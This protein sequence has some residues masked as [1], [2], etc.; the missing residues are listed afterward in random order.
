MK[1][2][3]TLILIIS[4]LNILAKH[5]KHLNHEQYLEKYGV[6][7]TSIAIIDLFF[8]KRNLSGNG[9]MS[10]LPVSASIALFAMPIGIV[11]TA[12]S[13]PLFVNGLLVKKK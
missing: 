1:Y 10:F 6:D 5:P 7:E 12:I 3:F 13:T 9:Q 11:T 8:E 4:S 2:L